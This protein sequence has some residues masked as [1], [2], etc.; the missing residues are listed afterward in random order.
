MNIKITDVAA[1]KV[2]TLLEKQGRTDA[3]LRVGIQGGGC[4]GF[5]Y[6][7]EFDAGPADDDCVFHGADDVQVFVDRKSLVYMDGTEIDYVDELHGAGFKF[8][9]PN[10]ED[11]CGCGE[12]FSI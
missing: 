1:A 10:A 6:I 9:N 2:R 11:T 8:R 12:S 5:T 7:M 3:G 4:S